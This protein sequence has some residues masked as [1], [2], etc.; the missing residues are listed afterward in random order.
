MK[1]QNNQDDFL[2]KW[3]KTSKKFQDL[4]IKT[5]KTFIKKVIN[6]IPILLGYSFMSWMFIGLYDTI[7]FDKTLIV[8]LVGVLWYGI[9]QNV[10]IP[11]TTPTSK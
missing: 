7:G 4:Y 1:N 6:F 10:K 2:I 9:R 8:L 5:F 3:E 11:P